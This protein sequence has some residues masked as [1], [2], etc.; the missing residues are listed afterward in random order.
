VFSFDNDMVEYMGRTTP[1]LTLKLWTNDRAG[2]GAEYL[3][4]PLK[5]ATLRDAS[6]HPIF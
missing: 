4:N 6:N 2:F 3:C 5:S 1:A